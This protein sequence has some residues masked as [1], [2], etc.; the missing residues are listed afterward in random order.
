M[1]SAQAPSTVKVEVGYAGG[2]MG[3]YRAHLAPDTSLTTVRAE[4]MTHFGV[5]DSTDAAG[6]R[7]V[8]TL[9]DGN[10]PVDLGKT[11]GDLATGK[12]ELELRLVREV[13]AG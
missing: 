10:A 13:I 2:R 11:V 9:T 12:R 6:N 3:P 8:Y 1:S 4:A 7:L 5:A